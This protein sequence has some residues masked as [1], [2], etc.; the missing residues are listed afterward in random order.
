MHRTSNEIQVLL[1]H[2]AV[3]SWAGVPGK[4]SDLQRLGSMNAHSSASEAEL[5]GL[6]ELRHLDGTTQLPKEIEVTSG[7]ARRPRTR[8]VKQD[9]QE[10]LRHIVADRKQRI[11]DIATRHYDQDSKISDI[12][13]V[14]AATVSRVHELYV[15]YSS[16][17]AQLTSRK[18]AKQDVLKAEYSSLAAAINDD[19]HAEA[20][21]S[22]SLGTGGLAN[23]Q[24]FRVHLE[25]YD[26]R[27]LE[28]LESDVQLLRYF[29]EVRS[30]LCTARMKLI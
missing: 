14:V 16:D 29:Q 12:H 27:N 7:T 13:N 17:G 19:H 28:I 2:K 25:Q 22:H 18:A 10:H 8:V 3:I 23:N 9:G 5:H 15:I 26:S 20:S 30:P 21:H 6:A 4:A 1:S 11:K 24:T